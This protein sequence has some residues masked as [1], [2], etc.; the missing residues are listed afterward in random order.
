M[1]VGRAGRGHESKQ[2]DGGAWL[3]GGT[4]GLQQTLDA[5]LVG[6][7]RVEKIWK[8]IQSGLFLRYELSDLIVSNRNV[9]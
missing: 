7:Y 9:I 2:L 5:R 1:P 8:I 4:G 6:R 3:D